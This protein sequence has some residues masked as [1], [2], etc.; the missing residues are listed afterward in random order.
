[1]ALLQQQWVS[2]VIIS[3]LSVIRIVP[4][5]LIVSVLRVASMLRKTIQ[6]MVTASIAFFM[7]P[8]R[9]AI[10]APVR[11][12]SG[13]C[14]R[15]QTTLWT[16]VSHRVCRLRAIMPVIWIPVLLVAHRFHGPS[17]HVAKPVSNC[18]S[19]LIQHC[20]VKSRTVRSKCIRVPR[21]LIWLLSM[22]L[23]KELRF[24]I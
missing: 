13:V 9:A 2:L 10:S 24:G 16:N 11:L 19:A 5:V 22:V 21:C 12:M 6:V 3:S 23:L 18:C 14:L 4:A 15:Y 20:P 1:M 7:I 8:S 17:T